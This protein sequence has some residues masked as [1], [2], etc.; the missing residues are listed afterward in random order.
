MRKLIIL[1]I[2]TFVIFKVFSGHYHQSL[3]ENSIPA[4]T[5]GTPTI[6]IRE[7]KFVP[8]LLIVKRGTTVTWI[9]SDTVL[10]AVVS[11]TFSSSTIPT[12][13]NY[14]FT[15][16]QKGTYDYICGLHPS[17]IGTVIVE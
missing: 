1:G 13:D 11:K 15:F 16:N 12:K 9:N 4:S 3:P 6:L 17:M 10:H 14:Q 2:V 7:Y 5:V 8:D